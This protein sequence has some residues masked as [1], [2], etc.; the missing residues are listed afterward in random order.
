M[1][2]PGEPVEPPE[3][4]V[5]PPE[6]PPQ[7]Q[8]ALPVLTLSSFPVSSRFGPARM[9]QRPSLIHSLLL[10]R[11]KSIEVDRVRAYIAYWLLFI[12]AATVGLIFG[13]AAGH[14]A[15]IN[16]L[17]ELAAPLITAEV[18]LLGAVTGFYFASQRPTS[19]EAPPV[20]AQGQKLP[21]QQAPENPNPEEPV[22]PSK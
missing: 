3:K 7:R 15:A 11:H 4:P 9:V 14:W 2:E 6:K 13:S 1:E 22:T 5:E 21:G 19:I 12:F 20:S 17:R 16:D 8:N 18:S 10:R